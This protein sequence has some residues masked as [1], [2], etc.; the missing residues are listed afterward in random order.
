MNSL[1]SF[2]SAIILRQFNLSQMSCMVLRISSGMLKL[3]D[4]VLLVHVTPNWLSLL[5]S[6]CS[7]IVHSFT[8]NLFRTQDLVFRH[9]AF[10]HACIPD[11][12]TCQLI[13]WDGTTR[14]LL[15]FKCYV[16]LSITC[17][18]GLEHLRYRHCQSSV[19]F[20]YLLSPPWASS[21]KYRIS[22][23]LTAWLALWNFV[24]LSA[25]SGFHVNLNL[26]YLDVFVFSYTVWWLLLPVSKEIYTPLG[27]GC[28]L[29]TLCYAMYC[30]YCCLPK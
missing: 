27:V 25:V 9:V 13:A 8:K 4:L 12:N 2:R 22:C 3:I 29:N 18:F 15:N 19:K 28:Y 30:M 20:Q 16:S 21:L 6:S 24:F 23:F 11:I 5:P 10:I 7:Q 14:F 1:N 17:A 26:T